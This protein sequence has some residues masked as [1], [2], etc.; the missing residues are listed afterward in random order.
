MK[1]FYDLHIHTAL[2][3]CADD[4]MT[5]NNVVNMAYIKGLNLIAITDHNTVKNCRACILAASELPIIVIPGMELQT[6]EDVHVLC[7][8]G[9][10]DDAEEFEKQ[11]DEYRVKLPNKPNKF[12]NQII[13]NENDEV[14][15]EYPY[16]LIAS[17]DLS[18]NSVIDLVES[19]NGVAVP[20]HLDRP[21]NSLLSNLGFMPT[22][23]KL[24]AIEISK[25]I[26]KKIFLNR[27]RRLEK[28]LLM[29]NSDAHDLVSISEPVEYW[30]FEE[31][32]DIEIVLNKLRG[33]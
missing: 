16:A 8:F 31:K 4:D 13:L 3:P 18:L 2:S 30:E 29:Q 19:F 26:E 24:G 15:G 27:N 32:P 5:P 1:I 9:S 23:I 21:S 20:A 14:T 25:R 11:L 10:V 28:Y 22:D 6:K 12:G 17:L 33:I 7:Y